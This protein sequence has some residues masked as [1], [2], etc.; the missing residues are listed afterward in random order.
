MLG[1]GGELRQERAEQMSVKLESVATDELPALSHT[2]PIVLFVQVL[3]L[4]NNK[5]QTIALCIAL[6][7]SY[8][9]SRFETK[10]WGIK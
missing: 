9:F 10:K 7:N 3:D 8:G 4:S 6:V 2:R 1:L 5:N